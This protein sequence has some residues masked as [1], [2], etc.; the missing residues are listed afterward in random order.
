MHLKR[1]TVE[2]EK[3]PGGSIQLLVCAW[4]PLVEDTVSSMCGLRHRS[5]SDTGGEIVSSL[6]LMGQNSTLVHVLE[7]VCL[8]KCF[9]IK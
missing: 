8:E 3:Q 1:Q 5:E 6:T 4:T 7:K 2:V 9:A